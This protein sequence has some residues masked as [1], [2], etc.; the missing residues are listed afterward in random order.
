[1]KIFI[2]GPMRGYPYFN[3]PA[4][5][6]AAAKLRAANHEVFTAAERN[7]QLGLSVD[8]EGR[9]SEAGLS[10][11]Q[12][13]AMDVNTITVWAEAIVTLDGWEN[14]DGARAE[15]WLG[16]AIGI[17]VYTLDEALSRPS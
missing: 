3:H 16:R 9:P 12:L 1:M 13:L 7:E 5:H 2:S 17:P 8:P 11:R 10:R 4:F 15:V 6:A 14:S